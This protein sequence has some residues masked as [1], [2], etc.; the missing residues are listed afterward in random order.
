MEQYKNKKVRLVLMNGFH[1]SGLILSLNE[2]FFV[3]L[4]KFGKEVTINKKSIQ[5]IEEVTK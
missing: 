1:Y 4:D 2:D 3:L 5:A